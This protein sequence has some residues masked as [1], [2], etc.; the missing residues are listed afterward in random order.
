[1][2]TRSLFT[3][4]YHYYF[5]F[6]LCCLLIWNIFLEITAFGH[7]A[8][9]DGGHEAL[10]A[11]QGCSWFRH[12]DG[13]QHAGDSWEFLASVHEGLPG[14]SLLLQVSQATNAT[15][16]AGLSTTTTA[17]LSV[18]PA[19]ST[20]VSSEPN[21]NHLVTGSTMALHDAAS[22]ARDSTG[23]SSASTCGASTSSSAN[24]C[25]V[26]CRLALLHSWPPP[27]SNTHYHGSCP[28]GT[29]IANFDSSHSWTMVSWATHSGGSYSIHHQCRTH[30]TCHSHVTPWNSNRDVPR[31]P[32]S[33][34]HTRVVGC[35]SRTPWPTYTW[36]TAIINIAIIFKNC[37]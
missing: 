32:K 22:L 31:V 27:C 29:S 3:L 15:P 30:D 4:N 6:L 1:M 34:F 7:S 5:F 13:G 20:G 37:F 25:G 33:A 18:G 8:A 2:F 9:G 11:C 26:T 19:T 21:P 14:P 36:Q 28:I 24:T 10:R 23:T 17:A 16:T 35:Q 12:P